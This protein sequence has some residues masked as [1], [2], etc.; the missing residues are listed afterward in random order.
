MK[1]FIFQK[2]TVAKCVFSNILLELNHP[3]VGQEVG[4]LMGE[5]SGSDFPDPMARDS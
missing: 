1:T 4:T 3:G 2:P 5:I